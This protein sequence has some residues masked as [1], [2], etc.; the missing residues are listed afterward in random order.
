MISQKIYHYLS[1]VFVLALVV[2]Q[3]MIFV[4]S[5]AAFG[6]RNDLQVMFID[7][8]S[9]ISTGEQVSLQAMLAAKTKNKLAT[10]LFNLENQDY[11][12]DLNFEAHLEDN[13]IWLADSVWDTT[14]YLPGIYQVSVVAK[15]YDQ[16]GIIKKDYQSEVKEV[17]VGEGDINFSLLDENLI[18]DNNF[19]ETLENIN[20]QPTE[21]NIEVPES[22]SSTIKIIEQAEDE[23]ETSSSELINLINPLDNTVVKQHYFQ[24]A[25]QTN[26]STDSVIVELIN[27]EDVVISTG[28]IKIPRTDGLSWVKTIVLDEDLFIDGEY[29]LIIKAIG[30]ETSQESFHL[31]LETQEKLK[32]VPTSTADLILNNEEAVSSTTEV[33]ETEKAEV[34]PVRE[35]TAAVDFTSGLSNLIASFYNTCSSSHLS[36]QDCLHFKAIVD[37]NL[38]QRCLDQQIYEATACEDYLNRVYVDFECQGKQIINSE[39]CKDYLSEKYSSSVNCQL[40][41]QEACQNVLRNNYLNRLVIKQKEQQAISEVIEPLVR[42]NIAVI[43]LDSQLVQQDIETNI[44]SLRADSQ[45]KVLV[46]GSSAKTVLESETKLTVTSRAVLIIDSDEDGL[47]D[48]L[49]KYY[50]TNPQD[51]DSDDDGYLDGEEINNGYNPL[52]QGS[53]LQE[54]TVLDQVILTERILDQPESLPDNLD[55]ALQIEEVVNLANNQTKLSG[56]AEQ[57]TWVTLYL[58]SQLPLVMT[59][60]TDDQG[61][62]E[63]ILDESLADGDHQVYLAVNDQNGQIIGQS[64]PFPFFV[65]NAQAVSADEYFNEEIINESDNYNFYYLVGGAGI[66]ILVLILLIF[67][68]R[69]KY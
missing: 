10:V 54:R 11:E 56:Q 43:D 20:T 48:D 36:D 49:E 1:F 33:E 29:Q 66:A 68:F 46:V 51:S 24:V 60:Q 69:K 31:V 44:L 3:A 12:L 26:T 59:T 7:L 6:G 37:N 13:G 35:N 47:P 23:K 32:E 18:G 30:L 40:N 8:P 64:E 17:Y 19:D 41:D 21:E 15:I 34:F 9:S 28:E 5:K 57:N 2:T 65:K 63:Y 42:Q 25:V 4:S 58:Y 62:W 22:N 50:Q 52:G 27:S 39:D 53:L 14:Q 45:S 38:D 16:Q 61:N 55:Q 67:L